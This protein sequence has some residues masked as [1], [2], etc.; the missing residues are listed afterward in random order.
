MSAEDAS[1]LEGLEGECVWCHKPTGRQAINPYDADIHDDWH[2]DWLHDE[3]EA[4]L[5]LEI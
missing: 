1:P 5:A 4:E 3:C 2:Y